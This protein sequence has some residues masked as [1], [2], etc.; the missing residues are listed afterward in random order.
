MARG[1]YLQSSSEG[2][3]QHRNLRQETPR[4]AQDRHSTGG[5]PVGE[6]SG[7]QGQTRKAGG[8]LRG[9]R[10]SADSADWTVG[11]QSAPQAS[12]SDAFGLDTD[13]ARPVPQANTC[14]S[15]PP[16][17]QASTWTASRARHASTVH[18]MGRGQDEGFGSA[19]SAQA[20]RAP[21]DV[22]QSRLQAIGV[23]N[24]D[25]QRRTKRHR[26]G[27]PRQRQ[28]PRQEQQSMEQQPVH[29]DRQ[30]QHQPGTRE[31]PLRLRNQYQ[32]QQ[33]CWL[34]H[35]HPEGAEREQPESW[36]C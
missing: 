1:R 17:L 5:P 4:R 11:T 9:G 2:C 28:K 7:E 31:C 13:L 16:A 8:P 12:T 26:R 35:Q 10:D 20:Q 3:S 32:Y 14:A 24:R 33:R 6:G 19:G 22:H 23:G 29:P 21:L 30:H 27:R 36:E 18:R 15:K 25:E 34:F